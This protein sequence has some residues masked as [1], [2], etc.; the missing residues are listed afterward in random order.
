MTTEAKGASV[1]HPARLAASEAKVLGPH[2][3]L[4]V[5]LSGGVVMVLE[6]L[7]TRLIAPIYGTSMHVWSALI[8]VTLLSLSVGY[9]LGGLLCDR[10]PHATTYCRVRPPAHTDTTARHLP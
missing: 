6:V 10:R 2:L 8:A 1:P 9:W 4:S 7:G 5:F 3:P